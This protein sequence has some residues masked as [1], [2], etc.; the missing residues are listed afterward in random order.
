[1]RAQVVALLADAHAVRLRFEGWDERFDEFCLCEEVVSRRRLRPREVACDGRR[2][3]STRA[4]P[5]GAGGAGPRARAPAAELCVGEEVTV[6]W[7][8][9][10][11][12]FS[13]R[14]V[15]TYRGPLLRVH[16][17]GLR[18]PDWDAWITPE[19]VIGKS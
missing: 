16:C 11:E 2:P 14:V 8:E 6:R 12:L 1:M 15:G 7:G 19:E 3:E 5:P 10:M 17:R 9:R 13:A 18:S 4:P